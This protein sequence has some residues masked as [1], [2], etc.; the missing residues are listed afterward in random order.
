MGVEGARESR[1]TQASARE[2]QRKREGARERERER[3]T[4]SA[5]FHLTPFKGPAKGVEEQT[6]RLH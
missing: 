3:E 2:R 4:I 5:A 6:G 1:R